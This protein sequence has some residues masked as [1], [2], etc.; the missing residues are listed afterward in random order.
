MD[1]TRY[2]KDD[3][4][5]EVCRHV[6]SK[7]EHKSI[8]KE[9]NDHIEDAQEEYEGLEISEF[10]GDPQDIGESLNDV[11]KPWIGYAW[12]ITN[13]IILILL[14]FISNT[15]I[16]YYKAT[17]GELVSTKIVRENSI[18][19]TF[20]KS[21][22]IFDKGSNY[23]FRVISISEDYLTIS[24]SVY[25]GNYSP[26]FIPDMI[27]QVNINGEQQNFT[28]QEIMVG[29]NNVYIQIPGYFEDVLYGEVNINNRILRAGGLK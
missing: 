6:Q 27:Q 20:L 29:S 26:V 9:L 19:Q 17:K 11:Y 10:M 21:K 15:G 16:S 8:K 18:D 22:S 3:F 7:V 24:L 13:I 12:V 23:Y 14:I 28:V 25:Q 5:N 1:S 2:S 4:V